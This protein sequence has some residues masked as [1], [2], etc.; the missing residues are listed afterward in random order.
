MA[1]T[2]PCEVLIF[3]LYQSLVFG[4]QAASSRRE[5]RSPHLSWWFSRREEA[6]WTP[7]NRVLIKTSHWIGWL[8]GASHILS[9]WSSSAGFSQ[10]A[11]MVEQRCIRAPWAGV[12]REGFAISG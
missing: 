7:P 9:V 10:P 1:A 2:Q 5:T 8:P 4:V 3:W 6:V 12:D 11:Q